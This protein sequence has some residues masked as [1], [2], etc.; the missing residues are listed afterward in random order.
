[1]RG[2][3]AGGTWLI[4]ICI[5]AGAAWM[6]PGRGNFAEQIALLPLAWTARFANTMAWVW[7]AAFA[8][9]GLACLFR[10]R[11]RAALGAAAAGL[12]GA[13]GV[14][15]WA[16]SCGCV[17][18]PSSSAWLEG[19]MVGLAAA[20]GLLAL[21]GVPDGRRRMKSG[22][23][24]V[25]AAAL[26]AGMQVGP[27]R[28]SYAQPAPASATELQVRIFLSASCPHCLE[29]APR[30]RSLAESTATTVF[31]GASSK[32]EIDAF[33]RRAGVTFRYVPLTMSQLGARAA[34]VPRTELVAGDRVLAEWREGIPE[35]AEISAVEKRSD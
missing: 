19:G 16:G 3:A 14:W 11:M 4:G 5:L 29:N 9:I 34:T 12:L 25:L 8:A 21:L 28:K 6:A 20:A 1:M 17:L 7:T 10:Y 26:L 32:A 30:V 33:F 2:I 15:R 22:V 18:R 13:A 35:L 31:I 27:L 23:T 24:G